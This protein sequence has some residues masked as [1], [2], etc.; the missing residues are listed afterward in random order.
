MLGCARL[1]RCKVCGADNSQ[2]ASACYRC[3]G[4]LVLP[5]TDTMVRPRRETREPE[6]C[7]AAIT[8]VNAGKEYQITRPSV[9]VGRHP[10]QNQ[11]VLDDPEVS[12]QHARIFVQ[13]D[14]GIRIEDTSTNGTY[15]NE[16]AIEEGNLR[17]GDKIRFGLSSLNTFVLMSR[18]PEAQSGPAPAPAHASSRPATVIMR[19]EDEALLP[20]PRLQLILDQY[21]VED[22]VLKPPRMQ[23]GSTKGTGR[24]TVEH[25]DVAPFHAELQ[26][27]PDGRVA[28]IDRSETGIFI[29][30]ERISEH[31]LQEGDLIRLGGCETRLLLFRE[32]R[33]R[34]ITLRDIELDRPVVTLGRDRTNTVPLDH[35]TV[36]RFHAKIIRSDKGYQLIDG[37]SSNGTF[38]NGVRITSQQLKPRDRITLGAI[39]LVFDGRQIEQQTS[40]GVRLCAR[41]L[42][43]EAKDPN[44]GKTLVLL[45]GVSLNIEPREFVGL[46]GPAGAGKTTLMHA[47]NGFRQADEGRVLFNN[48]DLYQDYAALRS[49]IGYV[50]QEDILH[51]SLTVKQC[52]YYSARL[53][54]PDDYDEKEIWSRVIEVMKVLDLA[55]RAEVPVLSLSGGQRKRVSLGLELLSKPTLLFMDEP[56]AGQ[57]PRTEMKL[58]QLFREVANRGSTV[59]VTTHLLGSFSL[60]DKV[61]I[62]VRGKLAYFGPSQEM[63][64][65]F[66]TDRPHNVFDRLQE[67]SADDWARDFARSDLYREFAATAPADEKRSAAA[68]REAPPRP[69]SS[70]KSGIRQFSTL[71]S[72]LVSLR[73]PDPSSI[74][75]LL[76]PPA[77]I[78]VLVGL[79]KGMPNEPKSLFMIIFASLWFGCSAAVREIVDE[80]AIYRRERRRNLK[81]ITYLGSKLTYLASTAAAQS[82]LFITILTLMGA[83]ENH[84]LLASVVMWVMAIQGALIGL[85]ISAVSPTPERAL[86]L[87]PLALIPQ[88]LLAGLFVPVAKPQPFVPDINKEQRRI[89]LQQLPEVIIPRPMGAVLRYGISPFMVARWG[90]ETLAEIYVHD[91]YENPEKPYS[92]SILNSITVSLHPGEVEEARGYLK[93]LNQALQHPG[94]AQEQNGKEPASSL[95]SYAAILS[96]FLVVT[97][98]M[99]GWAVKR[100]DDR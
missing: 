59:I 18:I 42:R 92:Y 100:K 7:L 6:F 5:P 80:Q 56:T 9:T 35:P 68:A 72:R 58:M 87:F 41:G 90:L 85:L 83:Q 91:L 12:R 23:I 25:P 17:L 94:A 24:I 45:D 40:S 88:L 38:V 63:L 55:E 33:R 36:S 11:I 66:R 37:G 78:A 14:G 10:G 22:I 50:P 97:L 15:V 77:A 70:I 4:A 52:L 64:S 26:F 69:Q 29:N 1:K 44:T 61:A 28:I 95:P 98:L 8:G 3:G 13:P 62:V 46:L 82:L 30:G 96:I 65:Y 81:I 84:F 60:L 51:A 39:Q 21:A 57:D 76:V 20:Q 79:M 75:S 19:P 71:L 99:T 2:D 48:W 73:L 34:A 31:I 86:Q 49:F 74:L 16:R 43:R 47:L 89:E 93:S 27:R 67:K 54:L 32:P 53:R